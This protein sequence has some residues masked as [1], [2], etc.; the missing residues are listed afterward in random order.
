MFVSNR[1]K[2]YRPQPRKKL[3]RVQVL[4]RIDPAARKLSKIEEQ[5]QDKSFLFQRDNTSKGYDHEQS[6]LGSSLDEDVFCSC[7]YCTQYCKD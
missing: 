5:H 2:K 6:V 1:L 4:V 3:S 7:Y